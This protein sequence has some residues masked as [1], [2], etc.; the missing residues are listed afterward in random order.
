MGEVF[1]ERTPRVVAARKLTRRA[2]RDAAGQFLAEGPQAVREALA[3]DPPPVEL[4]VTDAAAD[5]H[6]ELVERAQAAG[7]PVS[8]V[9][10]RAAAALSETATPQGI[11]AVCR[12]V[13]VPL[14]AALD[15]SPGLVVACDQIRDPGNLG[16]VIRCADAFGADSVLITGDSV[17]LYNGKTV[18][19][20][21]G[22]LFH[23]PI[24]SG[25]DLGEA[26]EVARAAGLQV[27]GADGAGDRTIDGL[28]AAGEL[29]RPT[30]WVLGN[31][32]WGLPPDRAALLDG[33]VALPM[34][35]RAESL[36]L[37][38]AAAVFLY[39]SAT[40]QHR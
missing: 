27:L 2:G 16:T 21:T 32:A 22:S 25:A 23:L 11:V 31:E 37:S 36:N 34:Y 24:T 39:A 29:S 33:L 30:M 8:A 38:T 40:A 1:T 28:G 26:V 19:A 18:R 3:H 15:G 12:T 20:S 9:S 5:R 6:A 7:V 17:D 35:G 4:F 10:A 14:A 13:D